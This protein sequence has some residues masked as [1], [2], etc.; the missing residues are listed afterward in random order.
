MFVKLSHHFYM[1]LQVLD[2]PHI[3]VISDL[4]KENNKHYLSVYIQDLSTYFIN[5]TK[6][7]GNSL[8]G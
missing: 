4:L 8:W 6:G 7:R 5:E 3:K 2:E 1:I